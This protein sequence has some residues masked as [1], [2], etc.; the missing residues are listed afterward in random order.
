MLPYSCTVHVRIVFVN[1]SEK[2]PGTERGRVDVSVRLL[3]PVIVSAVFII[4]MNGSM[5]NV[6]LP[7]I[8]E[9]FG[10]SEGQAGWVISGYLLVFAVGI[11]LYGRLAD[12]YSLRKA[13]SVGLVGFAAA[14]DPVTSCFADRRNPRSRA[15]PASRS[16]SCRRP[17]CSRDITVPIGVCIISAISL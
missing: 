2:V 1:E 5:V 4:V 11:P 3:L 12:V 7:T 15:T 8:G 10:V 17:R 16:R 13:F 14:H 9:E 6:A